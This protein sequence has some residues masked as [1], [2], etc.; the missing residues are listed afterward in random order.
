MDMDTITICL[1]VWHSGFIV[2][3]TIYCALGIP[4]GITGSKSIKY[5]K[6]ILLSCLSWVLFI[7]WLFTKII[8]EPDEK[9]NY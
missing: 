9:D 2:N 3:I 6:V 5:L 1:F 8:G 4:S 7:L